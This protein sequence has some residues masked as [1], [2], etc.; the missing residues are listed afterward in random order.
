MDLIE[1]SKAGEHI[2]VCLEG[3]AHRNCA[4]IY[5]HPEGF[6]FL[7]IGWPDPTFSGHPEHVVRGVI[8][9]EDPWLVGTSMF[10]RVET[11]Y[12]TLPDWLRDEWHAWLYHKQRLGDRATRDAGAAML[13]ERGIRVTD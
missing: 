4:E 3:G 6:V 11:A 10:F 5:R 9:A 2:A 7:D 8:D 12:W 1:A 13:R